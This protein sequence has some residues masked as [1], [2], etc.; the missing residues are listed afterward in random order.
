MIINFRKIIHFTGLFILTSNILS[1]DKEQ[2]LSL[3]SIFSDHMVLQ[4]NSEVEFWGKAK[5]F[6]KIIIKSSWGS[7]SEIKTDKSG[8]WELQIDTPSAGG[9]FQVEVKSSHDSKTFIDVMVGEVWLASGQSNMAWKLNQCEECID[10]QET[11]ILNADFNQIR[12][13][14]H[15]TDLSKTIIDSQK[16]KIVNPENAAERDGEYAIE[17]FSAVGYFFA[18]EL[19]KK[20]NVPIGIIGSYW[21]GTRVEAWTSRKN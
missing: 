18:R 10:N 19:H 17:S 21:G 15:P 12:F 16:W 5:P 2:P 1:F 13:F 4:Q 3:P 7:Y 8:N 11:E 20:L 14:N 6:D 9:P